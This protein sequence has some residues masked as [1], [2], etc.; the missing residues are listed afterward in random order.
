MAR[1]PTKDLRKTRGHFAI[2]SGK[3]RRTTSRSATG[4]LRTWPQLAYFV[5]CLVKSGHHLDFLNSRPSR[6]GGRAQCFSRPIASRLWSIAFKMSS[7]RE[8]TFTPLPAFVEAR[9]LHQGNPQRPWARWLILRGPR[10]HQ[11]GDKIDQCSYLDLLHTPLHIACSSTLE[12]P[13]K[14]G[15]S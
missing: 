15:F 3:R 5:R 13:I 6:G 1:A 14:Y 4:P 10:S 8:R 12:K 7:A 2:G 9:Y 11:S